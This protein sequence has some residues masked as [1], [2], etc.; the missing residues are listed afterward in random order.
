VWSIDAVGLV[1]LDLVVTH[2]LDPAAAVVLAVDDT[3][4]K[5]ASWWFR[6]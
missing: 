1:V 4:L 2:L 5:G 3:A 6:A